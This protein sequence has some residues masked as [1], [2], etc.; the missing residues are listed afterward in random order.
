LQ[1]YDLQGGMERDDSEITLVKQI[2]VDV[3]RTAP[4]VA[5][6]HQSAIQKSLERILFI[7]AI[8]NPASSYVQG[9]ND[10]VT[11]FLGVFLSEVNGAGMG[12]EC[13]LNGA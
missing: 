13:S 7:R 8:R 10:L 2:G 11:P 3:P 1:Y 6:F 9:I 5:F 12:P 4:G